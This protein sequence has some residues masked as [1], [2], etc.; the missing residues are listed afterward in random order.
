MNEIRQRKFET[1]TDIFQKYEEY[2]GK[3]RLEKAINELKDKLSE[4]E[5]ETLQRAFGGFKNYIFRALAGSELVFV[6]FKEKKQEYD[7]FKLDFDTMEGIT[8][9]YAQQLMKKE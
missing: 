7:D 9:E 5:F 1:L 6:S 8:N 4:S 2:R 3:S